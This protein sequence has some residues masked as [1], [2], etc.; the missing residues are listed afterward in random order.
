MPQLTFMLMEVVNGLT[1][2]GAYPAPHRSPVAVLAG[3]LVTSLCC[4]C[5]T[6]WLIVLCTHMHCHDVHG[7]HASV[8]LDSSYLALSIRSFTSFTLQL[9]GV[10]ILSVLV[11]LFIS[12]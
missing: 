10:I 7:D 6:V 4:H 8:C 11:L 5:S 3:E 1:A 2:L 9:E 12:L